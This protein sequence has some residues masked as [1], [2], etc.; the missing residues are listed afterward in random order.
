MHFRN[1]VDKWCK[2]NCN[3]ED[4]PQL[5]KINTEICE[6]TFARFNSYA[7]FLKYCNRERFHFILDRLIEFHNTVKLNNVTKK[8]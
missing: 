1:H 6:Q 4:A 5:K 7:K 8:N 3:P 2:K